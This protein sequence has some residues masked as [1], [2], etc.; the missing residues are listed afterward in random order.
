[1]KRPRYDANPDVDEV[2]HY[3]GA[4]AAAEARRRA[5]VETRLSAAMLASCARDRAFWNAEEHAERRSNVTFAVSALVLALVI[6]LS[7]VL[8]VTR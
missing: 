1:V 5:E 8:W 4:G 3:S 2:L 7:I 6:G